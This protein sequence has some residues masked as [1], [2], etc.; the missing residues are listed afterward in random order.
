MQRRRLKLHGGNA[1][2]SCN[3][4]GLSDPDEQMQ[5]AHHFAE[6]AGRYFSQQQGS[7]LAQ[8]NEINRL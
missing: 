6:V 1:G 7:N 4:R 2:F 3:F 5:F 8:V